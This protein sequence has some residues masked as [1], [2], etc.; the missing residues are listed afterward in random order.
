MRDA[1]RAIRCDGMDP[2]RLCPDDFTGPERYRMIE[3][4]LHAHAFPG[5]MEGRV[6][7]WRVQRRTYTLAEWELNGQ[8]RFVQEVSAAAMSELDEID[9]MVYDLS[10]LRRL[11]GND[12]PTLCARLAA[13][14]RTVYRLRLEAMR[15]DLALLGR[16]ARGLSSVSAASE[17]SYRIAFYEHAFEARIRTGGRLAT[18]LTKGE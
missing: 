11:I 16:K 4:V 3:A 5:G 17:I 7:E 12:G 1:L 6:P 8:R 13:A 14:D 15:A 10:P 9:Y 2:G 18:W